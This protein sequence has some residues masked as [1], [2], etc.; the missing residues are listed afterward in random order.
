[1]RTIEKLAALILAAVAALSAG[2]Q[3]PVE[4]EER[5]SGQV[6]A[7]PS[8]AGAWKALGL[9]RASRG[10][11]E[12]AAEALEHACSL[13]PADAESCYYYG[14]SLFALGRYG[15]AVQPLESALRASPTELRWRVYRALARN[16]EWLGR[17]ADA[18][19]NFHQAIRLGRGRADSAEDPRVDFG[20]Y[21]YRQGRTAEALAPLREAAAE[22]S[23]G[24]RAHSE[25]ACCCN[26][27]GRR[28]WLSRSKKPCG[29]TR[30]IGRLTSCSDGPTSR[31]AEPKTPPVNS[32]PA[33]KASNAL[34]APRR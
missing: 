9:L 18:E 1:V 28:R 5:Y 15:D 25:L 17:G 7:R 34:K 10:R 14:R 8:D 16:F 33:S 4:A 20:S 3:T 11:L 13:R 23:A 22:A 6:E 29:W 26:S 19:Q 27:T 24:P 12:A 21:L 2:P 31:W 30:E 32:Q